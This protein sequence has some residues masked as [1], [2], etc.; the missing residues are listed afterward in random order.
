MAWL[1]GDHAAARAQS[2]VRS[3]Q[4]GSNFD[5]FNSAALRAT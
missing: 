3:P 1:G 4:I 2:P 5:A